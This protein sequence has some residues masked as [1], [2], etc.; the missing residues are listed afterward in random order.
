MNG[1]IQVAGISGTGA[2]N[3]NRPLP[4][5]VV[6]GDIIPCHVQA[7]THRNDGVYNNG[8]FEQSSYKVWFED[9]IDRDEDFNVERI[10]LT[11]NRRN[12]GEWQVQNV[13][14]KPLTGRIELIVGNRI[15]RQI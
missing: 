6:Y 4:A 8:V 15:N 13:S 7:Y 1:H 3:F 14:Y 9:Y 11:H 2:D 12:L 10:K 5:D